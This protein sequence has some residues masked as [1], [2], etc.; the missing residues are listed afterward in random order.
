LKE[1]LSHEG[2]P[3]TL[4]NSIVSESRLLSGSQVGPDSL[5]GSSSSLS[6]SQVSISSQPNLASSSVNLSSSRSSFTE[7]SPN[8]CISLNTQSRVRVSLPEPHPNVLKIIKLLKTIEYPQSLPML[9][10]I[11][12]KGKR[13]EG[14]FKYS[15]G[16]YYGTYEN[17]VRSGKGIFIFARD[18]SFY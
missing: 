15:L 12:G 4:K 3:T 10:N 2:S 14:P 18:G 6:G 5:N 11:I 9:Q 16:T 13:D 1:L 8:S 17:G 7:N